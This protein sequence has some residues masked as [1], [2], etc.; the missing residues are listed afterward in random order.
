MFER[1]LNFQFYSDLQR[2]IVVCRNRAP[3]PGEQME[4]LPVNEGAKRIIYGAVAFVPN[5]NDSGNVLIVAGMAS[6]AQEIAVDFVTNEKLLN[7]FANKIWKDGHRLPYFE[8]LIRTITLAGVA[9]EPEV[10]A[11]RVLEP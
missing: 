9:Q 10:I 7:P 4:Y 1:K 6:G 3:Q 11:Y 2:D 8:V 5:L